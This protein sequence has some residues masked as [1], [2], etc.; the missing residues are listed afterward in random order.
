MDDASSE[1]QEDKLIAWIERHIGKVLRIEPQARWR[2]AWIVDVERDGE[3]APLYVKG[4]RE[5]HAMTPL[6]LEGAAL[7]IL[8]ANGIK[9]PFQYGYCEEADAI[10]MERLDGQSRLEGV[11]DIAARDRI[12]DQYVA[13]MVAFHALDPAL[14]IAA[15]FAMSDDPADLRLTQ[16]KRV[17]TMYLSRKNESAPTPEPC[18]AFLRRWIHRNVPPGAIKPAFIT[19]D[20]FQMLYRDDGLVAVMDLEMACIGDPLFDLAC[21]RMRDLSEKTGT[22]ATITRRYAELSGTTVDLTALRFHLV[23][24]AAASALLISDVMVNPTPQTDY[25]E[26]FV[27]YH[28]SLRIALEAMAEA[29]AVTLDPFLEPE[30]TTNADSVH[31]RMLAHAIER[32][33]ASGDM[34]RYQRGKAEAETAYLARRARFG[35]AL[36][37]ADRADLLAILS[38]A[39]ADADEAEAALEA[40]VQSAG[41][42]W[43]ERLLRLL[44]RRAMRQCFLADIPQNLRLKRFLRESIAPLY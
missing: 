18:T 30:P 27:Y 15:G 25:F 10:V 1:S 33:P 34:E 31:L 5:T 13:A 3:V 22:A 37:R 9:A 2:A 4:A 28:G 42:E 11:A 29:M 39:P 23:A 26:Y 36:D 44:H 24:F 35:G 40:F 43:D 14:F 21:I 32:I 41:P 8:H 17:E 7:G 16:F 19:G 38:D 20:A 12:V 6:R